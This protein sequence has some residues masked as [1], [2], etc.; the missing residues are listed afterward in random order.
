M[1]F[2][3]Q[4]RILP[5]IFFPYKTHNRLYHFIFTEDVKKNT[6]LSVVTSED[7]TVQSF[8]SIGDLR[9][10]GYEG[11]R[12]GYIFYSTLPIVC[13]GSS[14]IAYSKQWEK[15]VNEKRFPIQPFGVSLLLKT[16]AFY[17]YHQ[18]NKVSLAVSP[19]IALKIRENLEI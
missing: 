6:L 5:Y 13:H 18:K 11:G 8:F 17:L 19:S 9:V 2:E 14:I 7:I 4:V 12:C 1:Q 16:P 10:N 3:L 15:A